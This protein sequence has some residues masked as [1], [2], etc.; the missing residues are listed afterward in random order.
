M[1]LVI[2]ATEDD[3]MDFMLAELAEVAAVCTWPTIAA[4]AY[5]QAVNAVLRTAKIETVD[6]LSADLIEL[7][8]RVEIW[9]RVVTRFSTSVDFSADGLSAKQTDLFD[10][11]QKMLD[12]WL[13]E[14][15][16]AGFYQTLDS[17]ES[18]STRHPIN[19]TW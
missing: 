11:A 8:A 16:R 5:Q 17:N 15:R 13:G 9:R 1:P 7:L 4:P 10:N 12:H 18:R 14:A 19:F 3:L 6:L 2:Y